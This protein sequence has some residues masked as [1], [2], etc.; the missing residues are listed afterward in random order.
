MSTLERFKLLS[1][2]QH[3][4]TKMTSLAPI[5]SDTVFA[6][7]WLLLAITIRWRPLTGILKISPVPPQQR[8]RTEQSIGAGRSIEKCLL[9]LLCLIFNLYSF[10]HHSWRWNHH[11][12]SGRLL[13]LEFPLDIRGIASPALLCHK[14]PA[15]GTQSPLLGALGRNAPY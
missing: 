9:N 7:C 10:R 2:T 5:Q 8:R 11:I 6:L 14:E 1:S 3:A 13:N 4:T 12:Y 15:Q